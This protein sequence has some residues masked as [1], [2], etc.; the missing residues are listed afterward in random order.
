VQIEVIM[1][2]IEYLEGFAPVS[3][4][5][6]ITSIFVIEVYTILRVSE[7][8]DHYI[9]SGIVD[10]ILKTSQDK[11]DQPYLIILDVMAKNVHSQK[12]F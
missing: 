10:T 7:L 5:R 1:L 3:I 9:L 12:N 2:G 4:L 11:Y 8:F 6:K